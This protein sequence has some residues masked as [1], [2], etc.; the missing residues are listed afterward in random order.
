MFLKIPLLGIRGHSFKKF[1]GSTVPKSRFQ[2]KEEKTNEKFF[3][4]VVSYVY[5][6]VLGI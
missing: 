6:N 4:M 3:N 1:I 2:K 5:G